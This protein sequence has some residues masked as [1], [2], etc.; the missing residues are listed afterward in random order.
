MSVGEGGFFG[1][2][3]D[4]ACAVRRSGPLACWGGIDAQ[5]DRLVPARVP[6]RFRQVSAGPGSVCAL[7]QDGTMECWGALPATPGR[8]V[9]ITYDCGVT[10]G[11]VIVCG[12][13]KFPGCRFF[14]MSIG[15]DR[16]ARESDCAI[17]VDDSVDCGPGKPWFVLPVA[18]Q[19]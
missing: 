16:L 9:Q 13:I 18:G 14:S 5:G 4:F 7:K 12:A 8:F 10:A 6:G 1:G 15:V 11:H 2:G 3:N 17:R 19:G